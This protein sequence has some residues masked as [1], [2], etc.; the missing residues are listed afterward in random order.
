MLGERWTNQD[1]ER[2][3]GALTRQPAASHIPCAPL[4]AEATQEFTDR[5]RTLV[6]ALIRAVEEFGL[7]GPICTWLARVED[8]RVVDWQQV[9]GQLS[10]SATERS[11]T[12]S[13]D[14]QPRTVAA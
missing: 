9:A 6:M 11:P 7:T 3:Y 10:R 5:L 2:A 13:A 8:R 14:D 1:T 12:S 4:A